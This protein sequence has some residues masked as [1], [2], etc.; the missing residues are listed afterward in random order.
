[1]TRRQDTNGAE[2]ERDDICKFGLPATIKTLVDVTWDTCDER[3]N[4]LP[5]ATTPV[6]YAC[7]P[8]TAE[9]TCQVL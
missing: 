3:F 9:G 6:R 4:F 7:R 5:E 2:S 1:M 8:V